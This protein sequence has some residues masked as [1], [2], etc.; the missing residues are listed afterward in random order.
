V[1]TLNQ[2]EREP[3]PVAEQAVIIYAATNGYLDRITTDRVEEFNEG[4]QQRLRSENAELLDK[5]AGGDWED[6]TVSSVD[7]IVS[8]FA[9][10][11]GFDLDEDGQPLSE[12]EAGGNVRESRSSNGDGRSSDDED[13]ESE[14]DEESAS[15][16]EATPA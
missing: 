2:N 6:G 10:D 16:R 12:G 15:E 9:D 14:G 8:N 11:F 4:L 1:R 7:D 5:I 13:R 3:I